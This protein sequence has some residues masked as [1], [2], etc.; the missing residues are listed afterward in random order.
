MSATALSKSVAF[1]SGGCSGLG[2]ATVRH[3]LRHGA[4]ALV[5]DLHAEDHQAT[6][7]LTKLGRPLYDDEDQRQRCLFSNVDVTQPDTISL[8]LDRI[9]TEFGEPLNVAVNCAGVG[10][11]AKM[12]NKRGEANSDE[13]FLRTMAVNTT[14][15][16][17]VSRL[18]AER[19]QHREA[20]DDN[21]R[22]CIIHAASVAAFEG[23]VG[24]VGYSASKGAV[25]SMTLP[26]ARDLAHL[27]IRVMAIVS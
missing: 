6:A 26:M 21:L 11:S 13:F 22:G 23:G 7:T 1:V 2:A 12:I 15:T 27:G 17:Q 24:Q 4:K 25:V 9:E 3:L 5:A 19:M 16:F 8:A 14:G 10:Y 18:A 20:D